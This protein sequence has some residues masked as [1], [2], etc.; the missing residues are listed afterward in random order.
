MQDAVTET[1]AR[2]EET[3]NGQ[4]RTEGE[5]ALPEKEKNSLLPAVPEEILADGE[6][7]EEAI[8]RRQLKKKLKAQKKVEKEELREKLEI[9]LKEKKSS[10]KALAAAFPMVGL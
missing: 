10:T 4:L 5:T 9:D 7:F 6:T 3:Q 2:P 1:E 8:A